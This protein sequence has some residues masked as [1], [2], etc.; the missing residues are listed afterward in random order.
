MAACMSEEVVHGFD[1][2]KKA[3]VCHMDR[4]I[5]RLKVFLLLKLCDVNVR[6]RLTN[7]N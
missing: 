5:P 3:G 7:G 1:D 6:L 4:N 2:K